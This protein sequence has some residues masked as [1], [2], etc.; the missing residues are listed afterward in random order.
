VRSGGDLAIEIVA[1][2]G[3]KLVGIDC[4]G[5]VN[6]LEQEATVEI[7]DIKSA[8]TITLVFQPTG[9]SLMTMVVSGAPKWRLSTGRQ[10]GLWR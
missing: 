5:C 6:K 4:E 7:Q 10:P 8:L 9:A 1:E 3:Y 2:D